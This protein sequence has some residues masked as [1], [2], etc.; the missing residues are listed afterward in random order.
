MNWSS[1]FP[2]L[3]VACFGAALT[4]LIA[5]G[6]YVVQRRRQDLQIIRI[7]ADDLAT[8]RAL[9]LISPRAASG[10]SDDAQRCFSSVHAAQQQLA[11]LRNQVTSNRPLHAM[12]QEMVLATRAYKNS[13]ERHPDKWQ[14]ALMMVRAELVE[15]LRAIERATR[16]KAGALPD[17]GTADVVRDLM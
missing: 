11:A 5:Y 13:I 16:L 8:R 9:Q 6:T 10:A 7:L 4:V 17:P 12:L 1:F 3:V 14:F 2:D 15:R